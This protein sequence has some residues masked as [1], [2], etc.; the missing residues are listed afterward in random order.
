M[1]HLEPRTNHR[2]HRYT[3]QGIGQEQGESVDNFVAKIKNIAAKCKFRDSKEVEDRILDQ[4]IW[5]SNNPEVQ[6]SLIGRD[7]KLSL[8]NAID[9]ARSNEATKRQM[10]SLLSQ[11][12][13]QS[14]RFDSINRTK[15]N[16][17]KTDSNPIRCSYID[18]GKVITNPTKITV[19]RTEP[20]AE[21]V[22]N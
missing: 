19:Q 14:Q 2:I 12:I 6:K 3:L 8:N 22:V 15:L 18:A 21:N 10:N 17:E 9:I 1:E 11:N 5:G 7:E 4:L 13:G 16:S 20:H